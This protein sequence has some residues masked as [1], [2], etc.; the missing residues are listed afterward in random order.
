MG[1]L[2]AQ[3]STNKYTRQSADL[4]RVTTGTCYNMMV[5]REVGTSGGVTTSAAYRAMNQRED[6]LDAASVL[7]EVHSLELKD[8]TK[9]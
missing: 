8:Y 4:Y 3:T 6:R 9:C 2:H 7:E 5:R 1:A